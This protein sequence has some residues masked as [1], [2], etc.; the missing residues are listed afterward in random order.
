VMR[1]LSDDYMDA[2][3]AY[4]SGLVVGRGTISQ[5]GG[6]RQVTI[7]FPH[8]SLEARGISSS[9][10]LD[11][12]IR[13]GL[14]TIRERLQELLDTDIQKVSK[15][16]GVD[17]VARFMRNS[18]IWRN[19]LLL[20]DGA[21]SYPFFHIP[22]L[23]FEFL[24]GFADVAGNIRLANRYVD[25][26]NRVRLDVLN[27]PTN[28][29]LPVDLCTLL[30]EHLDVPVQLVTWGHPNMRREFREHQINVFADPFLSI[31]FSLGYKQR[32][33][34]ELAAWDRENFPH[35]SYAPCP[36]I[37]AIRERKPQHAEERN[38]ER[39]DPRLVGKHFNGYWQICRALGCTHRPVDSGQLSLEFTDD[40]EAEPDTSESEDLR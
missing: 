13:L 33:L 6:L 19:I 12:A 32:I 17:L 11:D 20:M 27:Y 35:A 18:M 14:D 23:F 9:F 21:T 4:L 30:Q 5:S 38:A 7:E 34:E 40:V 3:V 10:A 25:L 29:R 15:N 1:S 36:G 28:W 24:R 22:A 8:R 37:R 26:R 16:G 2:D 31:G 39:L